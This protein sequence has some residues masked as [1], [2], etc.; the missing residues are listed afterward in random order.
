MPDAKKILQDLSEGLM[1]IE[2]AERLLKAERLVVIDD[3]VRLDLHRVFRTG[4]PEVIYA[5]G[6]SPKMA[7]KIALKAARENN[8]AVITRASPEHRNEISRQLPTDFELDG[9]PDA[10]VYV[11]KHKDFQFKNTGGRVGI[12][13]AGTSDLPIAEEARVVVEVLGCEIIVAHDVG[14]AGFHRI[15]PPLKEMIENDVDAIIVCAGFEGTLPG[16]VAS[17]TD[18]PI[19]AV[20]TSIGYGV[21]KNGYSALI[22]MLASCSPGLAV[23]NIDNGFGAGVLAAQIA[24]R[25]ARYRQEKRETGVKNR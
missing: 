5:E 15:F 16:V 3:V 10:R 19:V 18:V 6:K 11:L 25:V 8:Y 9:N 7:A 14:I 12:I 22:T 24:N 2:Q 13:T 20:P 4:V 17:L 1:S 23:V 21:G